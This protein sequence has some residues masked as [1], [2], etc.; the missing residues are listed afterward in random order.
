MRGGACALA[1]L[2][3]QLHEALLFLAIRDQRVLGLFERAQDRL[4]VLGQR[5]RASPAFGA[6]QPRSRAAEIERRP[7]Q[8][9]RHRPCARVG[10]REQVAAAGQQAEEA[11]DGD[12]RKEIGCGDRPLARSLPQAAAPR[13]G[14]RAGVAAAVRIAERQRLGERRIRPR[15]E[16]DRRARPDARRSAR[17]DPV[18]ARCAIAVRSGGTLASIAATRAAA[19]ATSCSSPIPASRRTCR[20]AQRLPLV[21]ETALR[22]REL[23]LQS[24][25]L[26][27]VA[28]DLGGHAHSNV[29]ECCVERSAAVAA[30]A[31]ME[32]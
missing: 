10:L 23:L 19:L 15:R 13:R 3:R 5:L 17:P 21:G 8:R 29:I 31:R 32:D 7:A 26:E 28:C 16:I 4:L 2:V 1:R 11:R 18:A 9:R 27:V 22:D 25:Q 30:A 6:A 14:R 24:A 20:Q 12:A